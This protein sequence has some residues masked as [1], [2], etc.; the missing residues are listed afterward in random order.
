MGD[1]GQVGLDA[2]QV[3]DGVEQEVASV[4]LLAPALL[5][6]RELAF[7]GRPLQLAEVLLLL[8][9][10]QGGG[11]VVAHEDGGEAELGQEVLVHRIGLGQLLLAEAKPPADALG[12]EVEQA[13][14]DDVAGMLEV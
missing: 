14:V 9:Q 4:D 12:G 10:A 13:L 11:Q 7:G 3:A 1:G 5:L 2:L 8:H 6:A